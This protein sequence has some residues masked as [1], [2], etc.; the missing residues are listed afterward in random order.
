[1]QNLDLQ[2]PVAA[3]AAQQMKPL[4]LPALAAQA[5]SSFATLAHNVVL[6]ALLHHLAGTPST[7][8]H[9]LAHTQRKGNKQWHILQK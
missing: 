6:V 8:L 3:E 5:S 4:S 9:R 7:H 2:I 1:M